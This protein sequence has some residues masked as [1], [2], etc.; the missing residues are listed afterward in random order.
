MLRTDDNFTYFLND[1]LTEKE[2]I[3]KLSKAI[4]NEQ[5]ELVV[6]LLV[7]ADDYDKILTD[8]LRSKVNAIPALTSIVVKL[9]K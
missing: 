6:Q 1:S 2:R 4:L 8:E 5:E 7:N 9:S 3:F